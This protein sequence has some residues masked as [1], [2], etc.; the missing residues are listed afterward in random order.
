MIITFCGHSEIVSNDN[1]EEKVF[2]ILLSKINDTSVEFYLGGYGA[3]DN[4]AYKVCKRYKK[5]NNLAKLYFITP[6]L[7]DVYLK[8]K[9]E[10]SEYDDSIYPELEHIPKKFAINERNKW[11]IEQSDLLIAF[12]NYPFGGAVKSLHYAIK[13]NKNYLNIGTYQPK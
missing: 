2:D 10:L 13:L 11:M 12:V 4:I 1:L 3:F 5:I 9:M 8:N 6:Y 7:S